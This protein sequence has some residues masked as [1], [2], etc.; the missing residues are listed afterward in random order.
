MGQTTAERAATQADER[1]DSA[2]RPPA[3]SSAII[4]ATVILLVY[5]GYTLSIAGV[6]SPWIAKSFALTQPELARLFAWMSVSAFG[7]LMLARLADRV[8]RRRIIVAS[9]FLT[10]LCSAGAALSPHPIS[11]AVFQILISALLGGSVSSAIVLL[12]EELPVDRRAQGQGF[13]AF[14][15][16]VGGVLG[17]LL[18]PFLLKWGYSWRWLFAPSVAGAVLVW[19]VTRM[20]PPEFRFA[21][22]AAV[23]SR[24]QSHFYDI[25]HPLYRRRSLTL[26]ACAALD[27]MAGTAVN[28]WL[29]FEAVSIIGLAP[30]NASTLVVAGMVVGMVGFPIGAWTSERLGRVP[31]VAWFGG[32]AWLGAIAFYWGPAGTTNHPMYF[33]L[34]A[35]CWF[36]VG[37]SVMTV[38]ANAAATELFPADLRTTMVGWQMITGAVFSMLA[39]V[40]IAALIAPLGGLENVIRY[41]ALL[42]IPSAILFG[43]FI[44]ETRGMKLAQSSK[45]AEWD[46]LRGLSRNRPEERA[47]NSGQ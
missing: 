26:L 32:A 37:S 25:L 5:Q 17:Y 35:Y 30:G 46:R 38:G 3:A 39:Q 44:D 24:S 12:A 11:F 27:T 4:A 47:E 31:T 16:A 42:G 1:S 33:L 22:K 34:A 29:Y 28:G 45:E 43:M 2:E 20:L 41:F 7:S 6:A 40:V 8:G 21:R 10:P 9:L 18:I 15:S 23:E 14:A 13:A 36:K 19:P